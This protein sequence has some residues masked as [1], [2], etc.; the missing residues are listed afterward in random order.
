MFLIFSQR[1]KANEA[2]TH[3]LL[4]RMATPWNNLPKDIALAESVNSFKSNLD[5]SILD[6]SRKKH[7][8]I[9]SLR[10]A[11]GEAGDLIS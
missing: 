8:Y 5:L 7:T 6:G 9:Y 10:T 3:F 11:I 1:L 2:R 4:I